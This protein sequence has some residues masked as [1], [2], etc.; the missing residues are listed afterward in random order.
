MLA[1][2]TTTFLPRRATP[3]AT[4]A[5]SSAARRSTGRTAR[6]SRT[7]LTLNNVERVPELTP[8]ALYHD[9]LC[10][11]RPVIITGLWDG[12]PAGRL[13]S[14]SGALSALGHMP[15]PVGPNLLEEFLAGHERP[16][17]R[18]L[19]L[20]D[21]HD[22]LVAG[23]RQ[24]VLEHDTPEEVVAQL[25]TLPYLGLGDHDDFWVSQMFMAGPGS[26]LHLH[27]DMDMRSVVM[28]HLFGRKRYVLVD[29]AQTRK[30]A[31]GAMPN[32]PYTSGM[33]LQNFSPEDLVDFLRYVDAWDCV[34]EPGETLVI[35]ATTWHYV[36]YLD[37]ALS[38]NFRLPRNHYMRWLAE[39]IPNTTVELQALAQRFRDEDAVDG[40][41][42]EAFAALVA[43]AT[44][45][46]PSDEAQAVALDRLVA[47]LANRL[48]LPISAAPYQV[49]DVARRQYLEETGASTSPSSVPRRRLSSMRAGGARRRT[50][51]S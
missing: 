8:E 27:Y 29:A 31:A 16:Q 17:P 21:F 15:L 28:H 42:R 4:L 1:P 3:A 43:A 23:G 51:A 6:P 26:F 45:R 44:R 22:E 38:L 7:V 36:E 34:L 19:P 30:L 32:V 24:M 48:R 11:G 9:Y 47:D 39:A 5:E 18:W 10:R 50:R 14:R 33:Y 35:P 37:V 49:A 41:S 12:T 25:P 20:A 40:P 46:Y 2:V 13:T